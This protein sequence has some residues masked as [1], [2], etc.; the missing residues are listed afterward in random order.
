MTSSSTSA[1]SA[2]A[3]VANSVAR[4]SGAILAIILISYFMIVLDNSIVFTAMPK[5]HAAMR[6]SPA[7]MAWVQDACTLVFGGLLL[8]GARA[9]DLLGRRGSSP[10]DWRCSRWHRCWSA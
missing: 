3:P 5:I 8:L 9:S 4:H 7:G 6:F 10:S 1:A 2:P